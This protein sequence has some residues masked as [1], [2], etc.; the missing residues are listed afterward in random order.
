MRARRAKESK[1]PSGSKNKLGNRVEKENRVTKRSKVQTS[2]NRRSTLSY[3]K[4]KTDRKGR[5][6]TKFN[7]TR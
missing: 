7:G 3:N 1:Q 2:I 6:M 4:S 5:H